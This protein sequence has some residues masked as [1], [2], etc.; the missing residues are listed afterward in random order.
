MV[1]NAQAEDNSVIFV[2]EGFCTMSGFTRADVMQKSCLCTFLHGALTSSAAVQQLQEA[3][4]AMQE[5]AVE[6]LYY[7][8]D[9][10]CHL[11][12]WG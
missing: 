12:V 9:G 5:H 6:L 10:R 11:L 7:R 8:K 3:L 1:G 4:E 2:N